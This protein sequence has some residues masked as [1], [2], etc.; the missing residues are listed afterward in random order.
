MQNEPYIQGR[1]MKSITWLEESLKLQSPAMEPRETKSQRKS[2]K[3]K[4]H[5]IP[6]FPEQAPG[7]RPT[8]VVILVSDP[9]AVICRGRPGWLL[10]R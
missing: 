5:R 6:A 3:T 2:D 7:T 9:V 4:S 10:N 1:V 8:S